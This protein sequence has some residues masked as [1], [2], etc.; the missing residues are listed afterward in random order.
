MKYLFLKND[1][2]IFKTLSGVIRAGGSQS[3][4]HLFS[5]TSAADLLTG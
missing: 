4:S 1:L 3:F 2:N 5:V